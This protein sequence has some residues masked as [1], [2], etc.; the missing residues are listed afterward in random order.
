[1]SRTRA[2][3][4]CGG[5]WWPPPGRAACG[6]WPRWTAAGTPRRERGW[7]AGSLA[8]GDRRRWWRV[9]GG[10]W[11]W[12]RPCVARRAAWVGQAPDGCA[13]LG[14]R[15]CCRTLR[16]SPDPGVN[17]GPV[18]PRGEALPPRKQARVAHRLVERLDYDGARG[19]V[20]ITFHP[21]GSAARAQERARPQPQEPST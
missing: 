3:A 2:T 9:R 20:A 6:T 10:R 17:R 15:D 21:A 7:G 18:S 5:W 19:K 8:T 4:R 16:S 11:R 14:L 13:V 12:N 1:M